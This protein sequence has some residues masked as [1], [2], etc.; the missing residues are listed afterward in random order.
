[1]AY[2]FINYRGA[3]AL[4]KPFRDSLTQQGHTVYSIA[5]FDFSMSAALVAL[6]Q[7]DVV[8]AVW[9]D[10]A[11]ASD[12]FLSIAL[13]AQR[14]AKLISVRAPGVLI[15]ALPDEFRQPPSMP[16]S[17]T[18]GI[19]QRIR[20]IPVVP[21]SKSLPR[22]KPER[23]AGVG[24]SGG[25][26]YRVAPI[27][28]APAAQHETRKFAAAPRKSPTPQAAAEAG[29]LVHKIPEKMWVGE[30]EQVEVR[31]GREA[32]E[33]LAVGIVGR[34][35]ISIQ[36]I[37]IV[38]TMSVLLVSSQAT[39]LIEPQSEATQLVLNDILQGSDLE[40]DGFGRWNWLVTPKKTG[41]HQLVLK[42][43]AGLKDSRGVPTT[44]RLPDREFKIAVSVH[45][46]KTTARIVARAVI[47]FGGAL[48]ASFLGVVTQELWWPRIKELLQAW[49]VLG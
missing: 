43:S 37:P 7:F 25:A 41:P 8:I 1:M 34:G 18:N 27:G 46:G 3:N 42:V 48:A 14:R 9:T 10:D 36:D 31:L 5:D 39:F 21:G 29:R 11:A 32:T 17:D 19:A 12:Q 6:P 35:A 45:A 30:P 20:A 22:P 47:G 40:H 24:A 28:A 2:V 4:L 26:P 15:G 13:E 16:V 33:Q 38:E 44:V 49:G 23:I